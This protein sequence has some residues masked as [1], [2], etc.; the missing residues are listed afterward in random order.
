MFRHTFE[1]VHITKKCILLRLPIPPHPHPPNRPRRT[2]YPPEPNTTKKPPLFHSAEKPP[3]YIPNLR[4]SSSS[5]PFF[6]VT[7]ERAFLSR[8]IDQLANL[9]RTLARAIQISGGRDADWPLANRDRRI[10]SGRGHVARRVT[11][12][13]PASRGERRE[14]GWGRRSRVV[15]VDCGFFEW[16]IAGYCWWVVGKGEEGFG[17]KIYTFFL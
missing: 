12:G 7:I 11:G 10:S 5:S 6:V 16:G 17:V 4:P 2:V 14:R 13:I 8:R 3:T 9:L 15:A 1:T